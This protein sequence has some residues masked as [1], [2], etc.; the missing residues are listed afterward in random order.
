MRHPTEEEVYV[1]DDEL[2]FRQI[3]F[4]VIFW[5]FCFQRLSWIAAHVWN[6]A[7]SNGIP[8][9]EIPPWKT[10]LVQ[11]DQIGCLVFIWDVFLQEDFFFI[12]QNLPVHVPDD[13][14][15]EMFAFADKDG[16]GQLSYEEFEVDGAAWLKMP[17]WWLSPRSRPLFPSRISPT[18]GRPCRSFFSSNS[19]TFIIIYMFALLYQTFSP[20]SPSSCPAESNY[21]SPLLRRPSFVS[22][23][24]TLTVRIGSEEV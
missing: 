2:N 9:E 18:S 11:G 20:P 6:W 24:S 19:T 10:F 5:S 7:I 22:G 14:I 8:S 16:D 3:I 1:D 12:M 15:A 13:D 23:A 17:R 4:K 21:A